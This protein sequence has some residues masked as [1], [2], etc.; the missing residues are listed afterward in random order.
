MAAIAS[1]ELYESLVLA[2]HALEL[3]KWDSADAKA[4]AET[5]TAA[6]RLDNRHDRR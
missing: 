3:L 6:M 5:R 4:A 2:L 1:S